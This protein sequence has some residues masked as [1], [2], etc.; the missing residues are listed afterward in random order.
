MKKSLIAVMLV[1]FAIAVLMP[2]QAEARE[3]SKRER[4]I[5][6][7]LCGPLKAAAAVVKGIGET[8]TFQKPSV[9]AIPK[10]VR[11][12]TFDIIEGAA[13][14]VANKEPVDIDDVGAVNTAITDANIDWLVDGVVYGVG[15]GVITHNKCHIGEGHR[16]LLGWKA[17]AWTAGGVAA[18]D[19]VSDAFD[20]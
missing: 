11:Q 6:R 12:E 4:G 14:V 10:R 9:L 1:V 5:G 2:V 19:L 16:H 3:F 8:L 17:G 18:A 7:I 13:R 20:D 15:A